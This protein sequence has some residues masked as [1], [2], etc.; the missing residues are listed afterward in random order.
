MRRAWG[1]RTMAASALAL[2]AATLLAG[3]G[4]QGINSIPLP[5]TKGGGPGS[6]TIQAELPDVGHH[7]AELTRPCR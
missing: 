6:Y 7:P 2:S 3:C 4:W 5:G 1:I